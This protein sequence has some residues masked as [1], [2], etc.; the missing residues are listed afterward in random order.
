MLGAM[1]LAQ[2][3][4]KDS[5]EFA[6]KNE[7]RIDKD[8][9]EESIHYVVLKDYKLFHFYHEC[10]SSDLTCDVISLMDSQP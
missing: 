10:G 9:I 6:T 3:S 2:F 1:S 7:K 8:R 5:V 4:R